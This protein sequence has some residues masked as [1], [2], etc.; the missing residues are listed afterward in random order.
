MPRY[1]YTAR[2]QKGEIVSGS[3]EVKD[4]HELIQI[5]KNEHYF[6]IRAE[7]E[8]E[9]QRK[10]LSFSFQNLKA[11][12]FFFK[13]V[14]LKEK[15]FFARNL[16][17]MITSG[18]SLPKALKV[19]AEQ[20]KNKR[21]KNALLNISEN[22][23]KGESFSQSISSYP[24][25][26]SD[27]FQNMIKVG[28]E[29]GTMEKSLKTLA[30][31]MEKEKEIR[32]KI[33]S[34]LIYP[35]I[36]I[37]AMGGV[38]ILMLILVVPK[39]AEAFKEL[40]IELPLTTQ[41]VIFL[42]KFLSER[43]YLILL[44][45]FLL[46]ILARLFLKSDAVKK[47]RDSLLLKIPFI[48]TLIKKTNSALTAR[49]LA[50]LIIAGVPIV[51]GLETIS[52]T[53][54]NIYFRDSLEK[55]SQ[56]VKKGKK[57]ADSLKKYEKLYPSLFLEMFKIGEETGETSSILLKLADFYEEEVANVTKNLSA[58]IEPLLMI[59]IGIVVGFFAIS[60]I[61]PMYSILQGIN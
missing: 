29:S 14:S 33:L 13:K 22:I 44:L 23:I 20:T 57:I 2:T 10:S 6:L 51:Q 48:S 1:F 16:S 31:Q 61:Q 30:E 50:S 54:G 52:R 59:L 25:I 49:G 21:F 4:I 37:L 38:G 60:M 12:L 9:P 28:E 45:I 32:S 40:E 55:V 56:E 15:V 11:A 26:F 41:L 47:I 18:I 3:K 39:L 46:F 36:I 17:V 7:E 58:I 42:G 43:W 5:L 8:N 53:L 35:L 24:D 34:S 19:I 27:F